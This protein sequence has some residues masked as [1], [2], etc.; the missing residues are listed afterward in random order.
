MN[1][2]QIKTVEDTVYQIQTQ[3]QIQIQ[4]EDIVSHPK[5]RRSQHLQ[6]NDLALVLLEEPL[7]FNAETSSICAASEEPQTDQ[8]C[9]TAGWTSAGAGVRP[10][11]LFMPCVEVNID[12]IPI[13]CR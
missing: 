9:V 6:S 8:L 4:V 11:Q 3:I 13:L 2:T 7:E 1:G 12:M 10:T 5:T